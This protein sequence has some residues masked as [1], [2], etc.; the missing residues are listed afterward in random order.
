M[1]ERNFLELLAPFSLVI[2]ICVNGWSN[3]EGN[4]CVMIP[5]LRKWPPILIFLHLHQ[6]LPILLEQ[7]Y[8]P[9]YLRDDIYAGPWIKY[10]ANLKIRDL[11]IWCP[12]WLWTSL[13]HWVY[14]LLYMRIELSRS[15]DEQC[16]DHTI[17]RTKIFLHLIPIIN[18][19]S[20]P[21]QLRKIYQIMRTW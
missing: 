14:L 21:G 19:Y 5:N 7:L 6:S 17:I 1:I 2:F 13:R 4:F 3:D 10:D 18:K 12:S 11:A 9:L 16:L 20:T 8:C 15:M